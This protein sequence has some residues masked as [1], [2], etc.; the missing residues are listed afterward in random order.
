MAAD[1]QAVLLVDR[2]APHV[3]RVLI[4]RPDKRNA[5]DFEVRQLMLQALE[6]LVADPDVRAI[7]FGGVGGVF[8]AGGD[9]ASMAGLDAD[10]A[11]ERMQHIHRLC[12][13]IAALPVPVVSAIEGVA[14]GAAVGLALL[15]DYI[16]VGES[17]KILFPFL[18][19]GLAPDWG[20]LLTLP[21]R[22]GIGP[23]RRML[24]AGVP[25]LGPEAL[26][27]GLADE[28]VPDA[29]AMDAAVRK[30]AELA[31]LPGDAFARTKARLNHPSA[32]LAA[33]LSR[34]LA[35]QVHC[36]QS[37]EFAEGFGAFKQKRAPDFTRLPREPS[38]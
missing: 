1:V 5:I 14:A 29:Q 12:A 3:A 24:T 21:R 25:V 36:L 22:V 37:A 17:A 18:K 33:E 23:A 10:G 27:V 15:G 2:P 30:A 9:L 28:M 16:V 13:Q 20:Q 38:P 19:I 26:R 6:E 31:A 11:R 34:E 35:D 4:N 7:V 32:S 8:S